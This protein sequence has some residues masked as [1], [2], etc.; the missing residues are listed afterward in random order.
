MESELV[1]QLATKF[2]RVRR[3]PGIEATLL[4][5]QNEIR[6]RDPRFEKFVEDEISD[7]KKASKSLEAFFVK[8][9][10]PVT[11]RDED[12]AARSI[13]ANY[14]RQVPPLPPS[15]NE[16]IERLLQTARKTWK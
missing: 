2:W 15:P 9:G 14:E 7:R 10:L 12:E 13:R 8:S 4:R 16:N 5:T 3:I 11:E 1:F 6:C